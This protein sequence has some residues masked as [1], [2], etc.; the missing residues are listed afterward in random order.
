M[1]DGWSTDDGWWIMDDDA[2]ADDDDENSGWWDATAAVLLASA[3]IMKSLRL[4]RMCWWC[5]HRLV[6]ISC[7]ALGVLDLPGVPRV[8]QDPRHRVTIFFKLSHLPFQLFSSSLS[9]ET[10]RGLFFY[11][12]P[13]QH[14]NLRHGLV[15]SFSLTCL[16][17]L[18]FVP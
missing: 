17:F 7:D 11:L 5:R 2:D 1:D 13:S 6:A 3:D 4:T 8:P 16:T 18:S 15:L 9:G 14:V 10:N 12:V